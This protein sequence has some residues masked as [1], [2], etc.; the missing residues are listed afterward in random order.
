MTHRPGSCRQ[1][2]R[3]RHHCGPPLASVLPSALAAIFGLLM[4][5]QG[6]TFSLASPNP[7]A[8]PLC[9]KMPTASQAK[10]APKTH[11]GGLRASWHVPA[12]CAA[13]LLVATHSPRR[14]CAGVRLCARWGSGA[15]TALALTVHTTAVP[16]QCSS[17]ISS[18]ATPWLPRSTEADMGTRDERM[19]LAGSLV[20]PVQFTADSGTKSAA[21]QRRRA[22]VARRAGSARRTQRR[23]HAGAAG[24]CSERAARRTAGAKL[25]AQFGAAPFDLPYDPSCTRMKIQ[26]GLRTASRARCASGRESKTQA[27]S[28]DTES[29][30][31][32]IRANHSVST[33]KGGRDENAYW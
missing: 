12:V 17:G 7:V 15:S 24:A 18:T 2:T 16:S 5:V 19:P 26:L 31:V 14:R 27:T 21:P 30:G 33:L 28:E 22:R 11:V 25:Q 29:S 1:R 3:H 13:L 8:K 20:L 6:A 23:A 10:R 4:L 32:Y 9:V